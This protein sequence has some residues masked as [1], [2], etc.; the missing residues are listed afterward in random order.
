VSQ[1]SWVLAAVL[2]VV[3]VAAASAGLW[4][5]HI[6]ALFALVGGWLAAALVVRRDAQ[7]LGLD[8]NRWGW[9]V[10]MFGWLGLGYWIVNRRRL[11]SALE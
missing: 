5:W 3:V 10:L 9:V 11:S 7:R 2:A 6:P 1:R 4:T 8:G